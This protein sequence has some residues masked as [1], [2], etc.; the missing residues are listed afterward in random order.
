[1]GLPRVIHAGDEVTYVDRHGKAFAATLCHVSVIGQPP[2]TILARNADNRPDVVCAVAHRDSITRE[3][4]Y[5][6]WLLPEEM[7][8]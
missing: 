2:N 5:G 6:Y 7:E 3:E 1:M 4:G 8:D